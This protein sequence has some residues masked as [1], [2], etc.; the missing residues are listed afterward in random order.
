MADPEALDLALKALEP[1]FRKLKKEIRSFSLALDVSARTL[2]RVIGDPIKSRKARKLL[3]DGLGHPFLGAEDNFIML[4]SPSKLST[5][6]SIIQQFTTNVNAEDLLNTRT[7]AR[8]KFFLKKSRQAGARLRK[9]IDDYFEDVGKYTSPD[10]KLKIQ[11]QVFD[12]KGFMDISLQVPSGKQY[13]PLL[14]KAKQQLSAGILWGGTEEIQAIF[15][16]KATMLAEVTRKGRKAV[17]LQRFKKKQKK[18]KKSKKVRRTG[19]T[20]VYSFLDDSSDSNLDHLDILT[21]LQ[22]FI[23]DTVKR[24]PHMR[25][26]GSPIDP[27]KNYLRNVTG[28]FADSVKIEQVTA[29]ND[30]FYDYMHFPYDVFQ[31]GVHGPGR[32]PENIISGAVREIMATHFTNVRVGNIIPS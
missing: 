31:G 22:L 16:S 19:S 14:D 11:S 13:K 1:Q 27:N 29:N 3:I 23:N 24:F 2:N 18:Q 5:A 30:I 6:Q 17:S 32:D 25:D 20:P 8:K 12:K 28:R 9:G 4:S 7:E 15:Q 21:V 10:L 26:I